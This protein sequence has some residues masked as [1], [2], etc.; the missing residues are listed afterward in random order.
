[1]PDR[2][3]GVEIGSHPKFATGRQDRTE[4]FGSLSSLSTWSRKK[5]RRSVHL[6]D[7]SGV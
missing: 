2:G 4:I 7:S 6:P 3:R 5:G 1:M